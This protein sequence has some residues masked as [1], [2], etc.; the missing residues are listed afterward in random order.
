M[1]NNTIQK[2]QHSVSVPEG[3]VME[4]ELVGQETDFEN[5]G[6]PLSFD[7]PAQEESQPQQYATEIPE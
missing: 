3:F 4:Q 5:Q 2:Q 6:D 7:I 1:G